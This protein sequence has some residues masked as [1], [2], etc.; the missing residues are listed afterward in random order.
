MLAHGHCIVLLLS[1]CMW[2]ASNNFGN[3]HS[4]EN[5]FLA[6]GSLIS[7]AKV[8]NALISDYVIVC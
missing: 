3:T 5:R 8:E 2:L 4:N 7:N 6:F 1:S